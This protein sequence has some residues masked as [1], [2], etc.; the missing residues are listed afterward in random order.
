[1]LEQTAQLPLTFSKPVWTP[2]DYQKRAVA[3]M[4]SQACVGL[5][6]DPGLGKTAIALSA[7][8]LL[9]QQG[10]CKRMLVIAP[11]RPTF[12]VWPAEI[13]K[14]SN[15]SDLKYVILHGKD[16]QDL[17]D[18][19]ADVFITNVDT[20]GWLFAND[21]YR[22][23]SADILCVDESSKF[24]H[25]DTARFKAIKKYVGRFKRRW[26]LTGTP[27]PN[28]LI[29][30]FGQIYLLDEG[31]ALTPYITRFRI[32]YFYQGGFGGYTWV[33]QPWAMDAI[34]ERIG[35]MI[36][37]M[38][39]EDYLT[40]PDLQHINI[41]VDLPPEAA[42]TYR[43]ME[44]EFYLQLE[45][46]EVVAVNAAV[47]GGK[48]RQIANGCVYGEEDV[49]HTVHTAKL[50]AFVDL[51]EELAGQ[52]TLV[53]Y[54]FKHDLAAMLKKVP[55]PYLGGGVSPRQA[56]KIISDFNAGKTS[57][58]YGHPAS[59]GH[60]LN[61]QEAAHHVIFYGITWDLE[62][63]DQT[64]RRVYRQ[65]QTHK[66][67]VYHLVAAKTLDE[68]VLETLKDKDHT[69]A[70]LFRALSLYNRD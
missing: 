30:L 14:W 60:G 52:P 25:V 13:K 8:K 62:L 37:R 26:I 34:T 48:C 54:E 68:V 15:F 33:P 38:K 7:F 49:V 19:D 39:A 67:L 46:G 64:I 61:L 35:P 51:I 55:G 21:R 17:L 44:N 20:V 58:L 31:A 24:R 9:K 47:A 56:D 16:K 23:I 53:V 59:M 1:M 41:K 12:S 18:V 5:F 28:G 36:L 42:K 40:M 65:G 2:H 27:A 6:L 10:Y 63:Y 4:L 69:Q 22:Q 43:R 29:D 70:T 50:E 66:V 3:M 45:A 57:V 11:L 32:K